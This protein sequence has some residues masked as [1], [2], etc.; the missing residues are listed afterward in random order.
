LGG[1]VLEQTA[2]SSEKI[3][4]NPRHLC[5]PRCHYSYVRVPDNIIN[6]KQYDLFR[7]LLASSH[8]NTGS[9]WPLLSV[10]A[11]SNLLQMPDIDV[12]K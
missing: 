5:H 4:A 8:S 12:F 1:S 6:H 9:P 11:N 2:D 3:R 7:P 10:P